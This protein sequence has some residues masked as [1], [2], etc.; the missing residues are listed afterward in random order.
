MGHCWNTSKCHRLPVVAHVHTDV[1]LMAG[2][3]LA[4]LFARGRPPVVHQWPSV[5]NLTLLLLPACH[6]SYTSGYFA[7]HSH[8]WTTGVMLFGMLKLYVN[9][10]L[11]TTLTWKI[12][13]I[14][15]IPTSLRISY[16]IRQCS[17]SASKRLFCWIF[18]LHVL[19][20]IHNAHQNIP[21]H[22]LFNRWLSFSIPVNSEGGGSGGSTEPGAALTPC[23]LP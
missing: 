13:S 7:A 12:T 6:W 11:T 14:I 2:G 16:L 18:F 10:A 22:V 5:A 20:S 9:K 1:K 4:T 23:S 3:P 19:K 15:V 17:F 21:L 8:W